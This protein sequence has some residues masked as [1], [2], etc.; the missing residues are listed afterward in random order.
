MKTPLVR[1]LFPTVFALTLFSGTQSGEN[2]HGNG[3]A[4]EIEGVIVSPP[5]IAPGYKQGREE[6]VRLHGKNL[7]VEK[8]DFS[9]S[10][11]DYQLRPLE[12]VLQ[13]CERVASLD[14]SSSNI[15][16][17]GVAL[18]SR[19]LQGSCCSMFLQK[20]DLSDNSIA[21]RSKAQSSEAGIKL[22]ARSLNT[23]S[24]L[25][26]L[27]L[28]KN[29]MG[30][31]GFMALIETLEEKFWKILQEL[32]LA[33]N[34]ISEECVEQFTK[35]LQFCSQ[36][37]ILDLSNNSIGNEGAIKLARTLQQNKWCPWLLL[38]NL[39]HNFLDTETMV[40]VHNICGQ[41]AG[42]MVCLNRSKET[43]ARDPFH[44]SEPRGKRFGRW[45]MLRGSRWQED[46]ASIQ[47]A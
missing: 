24:A 36:L 21:G 20:L 9:G 35:I 38:I 1:Y 44:S 42:L 14:V 5:K 32:Y 2:G 30:G 39:K 11:L 25:R 22:L 12:Q 27:N 16:V 7:R 31:Q 41:R 13:Q 29:N 34:Q 28:S 10:N 45:G 33:D 47:G 4:S 3:A 37:T 6:D 26:T 8:L 43:S 46:P 19:L 17:Y 18:L 15:G 40:A 23:C